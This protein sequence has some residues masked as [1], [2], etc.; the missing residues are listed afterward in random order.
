MKRLI[1]I[2]AFL[3]LAV[4]ARAQSTIVSGTILDPN[5]KPYVNA[6]VTANL[7]NPSG[8]A[9]N[10]NGYPLTATTWTTNANSFA[11]FSMTIPDLA[12]IAPATGTYYSF[13]VCANSSQF[14]GQPAPP[15]FT[16]SSPA[17]PTSGCI[18]GSTISISA[19]LHAV[20]AP[21]P[22]TGGGTPGGSNTAV[23]F[24][25]SG[26]FGGD[27]SNLF[28]NSTTHLLSATGGFNQ[29]AACLW[30]GT[31]GCNVGLKP[32]PS[33]AYQY[34]S[35]NGS[36]SNDGL[37]AGS[38]KATISGAIS[39]LP[40]AGGVVQILPG[41]A[42]TITSDLK[43]GSAT[44][45]VHLQIPRNAVITVNV[46]D[47]SD[48]IQLYSKSSI[49]A[50]GETNAASCNFCLASTANVN[51]LLNTYPAAGNISSVSG[52]TFEG[53]SGATVTTALVELTNP[54]DI[55]TWSDDVIW[56]FFG[57]GLE[58][59]STASGGGVSPI[60]FD[61]L[62]VNGAGNAGAKPV[63]ING[64]NGGGA[65]ASLDFFGGSFTHP[66]TGG[67]PIIDIEGGSGGTGVYG[68]NIIGSQLESSN[69]GDIGVLVNNARNV[70]I[71]G[72]EFTAQAGIAGAACVKISG[73]ASINETVENIANVSTWTD[74]LD[75]T[76]NSYVDAN[77]LLS[78]YRTSSS[79]VPISTWA[80]SSYTG[81]GE[82]AQITTTGINAKSFVSLSASPAA[83]GIFR[84]AHGDTINFRNNANTG[85]D[86]IGAS[87]G[88]LPLWNGSAWPGGGSSPAGSQYDIQTNNG[89]GALAAIS[90]HS[91]L[92]GQVL[93]LV[94]AGAAVATTPTVS[95]G[96]GGSS[97]TVAY[98]ASCGTTTTGDFGDK[99]IIGA[100]GVLTIPDLSGT[101]C[102]GFWG[103]VWNSTSGSVTVS[104][105]TS[106]TFNVYGPNQGAAPTTGATSFALAA[107]QTASF[108]ADGATIYD[109]HLN[110]PL[111][112]PVL[113][114]STI[115]AP[116]QCSDT[117]G[118][119]TAQSCA[120]SPS[121]TPVKGS[122]IV[123]YT[124]T[125]NTGALTV[126]VNSSAADAV[127]KWQGTALASGDIKAN[128][129]V[130]LL[131]DGT[132][133]QIQNIG[134]APSG[135]GATAWSAIT[136]PTGNLALTMGADMS[137]FTYNAATGAGVNL[138]NLAD[139]ASNTGTGFLMNIATA[140][141]SN[142]GGLQLSAVGSSSG[143]FTNDNSL[144]IANPTAATSSQNQPS[145][146]LQFSGN[147]WNGASANDTLSEQLTYST[148]TNPQ[149]NLL[150][151]HAG[152]TN[153]QFNIQG[154][155]NMNFGLT[156]NGSGTGAAVNLNTGSGANVILSPTT[157]GNVLLKGS[158]SAAENIGVIRY[159]VAS[160]TGDA[161]EVQNSS[162]VSFLSV[163]S[164]GAPKITLGLSGSAGT[165]AMFP[166]S[167][168]FT[169]TL[170]SAATASN[171][172]N[173]FASV[174][175]NNDLFYCAVSSTTCTLTDAGYAYNSIPNAD[176]ANSSITIA[177][178]SVSL[179]GSTTSFPSPGAIGGTTAA[180]G[181]FT[182]LTANTQTN[183][184]A[185]GT[186]APV[187][188]GNATSGTITLEPVTGALGTVTLSLPDA[189]ATLLYNGGPGGTPSSLTLTNATGLPCGAMPALTGAVTS[190]AGGCATTLTTE[191]RTRQ[192]E[193]VWGGTGASNAL[194]SGDDAI[195]DQSCENLTG[196]TWTITE[197]ACRSDVAS[198][199]TTI[200]P[201]FGAS[202][203]GTTLLSAALT[204]GSSGAYA[205]TTGIANGSFLNTDNL[206]PV[207]AGTLT[208]TSIHLVIVYT[209]P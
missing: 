38:A 21:L 193:V 184:G 65:I 152:S 209:M 30:N 199:T 36:D 14:S 162:S 194:Q 75:D 67:L 78:S 24:N 175:A 156:A 16:Y 160:P 128:V 73:A 170:G 57:V 153:T 1:A 158:A 28:Y 137:T 81:A 4:S 132:N 27:T 185:S 111:A 116:L 164:G 138:F 64:A 84:L 188:F 5:N 90:N 95:V 48:A 141:A 6:T 174:P 66:G 2:F 118:S 190:S 119:A 44:Q 94:N 87:S 176:L 131:F 55:T 19:A 37:A 148:G 155:A 46:T 72:V 11:V 145:S 179:G 178:A 100:G 159:G 98:T 23:Q 125:T 12:Y 54:T 25:N 123:Y 56:N 110:D 18:T 114:G 70:W 102:A 124:T 202:G 147:I 88:D 91:A 80:G 61:N 173:F 171:T 168:N 96:N 157:T 108:S 207:M 20:A 79:T 42:A 113:S 192:C 53:V 105:Q 203:T 136:N 112:A 13:T 134:N 92:T 82:I 45:I 31:S 63:L 22:T 107:G 86:T 127:E 115:A 99:L 169:T 197:V 191:Y 10:W 60:V 7:I 172:V 120:T 15:C 117:S 51:T 83:A 101:N 198:N 151:S 206:N 133:W 68:V 106:D 140:S 146:Q 126:N 69:T 201:T 181:T 47:G 17:C 200:N 195:A 180:A 50:Y 186:L 40:A 144:Q 74:T 165:L 122:A 167:G 183:A 189:T 3:M 163:G 29:T 43:I 71:S 59:N 34:V 26:I 93:G 109:V 142:A 76:V 33:D 143:T 52:V 139:T 182:T 187:V 77:T 161:L 41:Y 204:C 154:P 8:L 103:S 39:A 121:F 104:R 205:T 97:I 166:S 177:G 49:A 196:S 130:V 58:V 9:A 32:A 35:S 135:G 150:F 85:D 89:S 129:P 208:G 149:V 62:T